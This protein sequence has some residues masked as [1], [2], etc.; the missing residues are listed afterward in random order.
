MCY[1]G[2]PPL[3]VCVYRG[4]LRFGSPQVL[5]F[6]QLVE[7]PARLER[8]FQR[9]PRWFRVVRHDNENRPREKVCHRATVTES[10]IQ[11][12]R[13]NLVAASR[14]GD[15]LLLKRM[16]TLDSRRG[17]VNYGGG[18]VGTT[19]QRGLLPGQPVLPNAPHTRIPRKDERTSTPS[20]PPPP[21]ALS[22]RMSELVQEVACSPRLAN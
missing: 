8:R 7:I 5:Q 11:S 14:R 13:P 3:L 1:N 10:P 19:D 17:S 21:E 20:K 15:V 22:V 18:R 6:A 9:S 16:K 2:R 12:W 4:R